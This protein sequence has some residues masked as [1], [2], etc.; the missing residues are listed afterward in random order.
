MN[1][2]AL[3]LPMKNHHQK[4]VFPFSRRCRPR[5]PTQANSTD[6]KIRRL[7]RRWQPGSPPAPP[8]WA[9][10]AFRKGGRTE[11]RQ[12]RWRWRPSIDVWRWRPWCPKRNM[13][14]SDS[15]P[16]W[17]SNCNRIGDIFGH[18]VY[19]LTVYLTLCRNIRLIWAVFKTPVR[20]WLITGDY[21]TQYI[22]DNDIL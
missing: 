8:G 13:T 11:G 4:L 21:T 6:F 9:H 1:F 2:P 22:G 17:Q 15:D 5:W 18:V 12:R 10:V 7:L 19:I 14:F 20:F 16:H 3:R